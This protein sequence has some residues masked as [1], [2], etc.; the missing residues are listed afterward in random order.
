[1]KCD[2]DACDE[3]P[4]VSVRYDIWNFEN[5]ASAPVDDIYEVLIITIMKRTLVGLKCR[6]IDR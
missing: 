4:I 3:V 6:N 2:L 1:M 5:N